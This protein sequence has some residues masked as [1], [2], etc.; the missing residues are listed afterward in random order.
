M[1]SDF[2]SKYFANRGAIYGVV[3]DRDKNQGTSIN[4]NSEKYENLFFVGGSV[5]PGSSIPMVV[6]GARLV[7]E[8]LDS[9]HQN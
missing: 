1:P 3:G 7:S 2:A 5:N 9:K 6:A 8:K 4:K